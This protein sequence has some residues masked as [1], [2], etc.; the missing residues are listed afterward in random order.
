MRG[1]V[2]LA[3]ETTTTGSSHRLVGNLRL[4][5]VQIL[6]VFKEVPR[7]SFGE[8]EV[9]FACRVVEALSRANIHSITRQEHGPLRDL[10]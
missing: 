4:R 5:S 10:Q 6:H 3:P 2:N 8:I 7:K 1:A 9:A